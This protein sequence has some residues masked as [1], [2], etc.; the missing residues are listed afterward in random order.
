MLPDLAFLESKFAN[1]A[2]AI[3]GVHS[4]KFDNERNT[5]P[6]RSAVLR[7]DISHPVVND[8]TMALWRAL[9]VS[10]WP[11]LAVVSPAGRLLLSLSGE[12]HRA[13]L[14]DVL[15]A[16]IEYYGERG[17][18]DATPLPLTL[19]KTKNPLLAASPLRFPGKIALDS[20]QGRLF[21][22]DSGNHRILVTTLQGKFLTAF[23]GNGAGL[24]D[25][26]AATAVFNRP[27]GVTYSSVR[28]C[29]YVCDTEN[30]AVREIDLTSGQVRTLVG[31]G[32]RAQDDYRG[33]AAGTAQ[34]LNSPWDCCLISSLTTSTSLEKESQENSNS[35]SGALATNKTTEEEEM[36][37]VAMAGQH[38]LWSVGLDSG[39]A[40]A[41][42]GTGAE[43]NQNGATGGSTAWAQ[44]SGVTFIPHPINQVLVADS[45]SSSIRRLNLLTGGGAACI[46]GD[47]LF[48]DNLF[49]F[50]DLDGAGTSALL[51]HPLGVAAVG[52]TAWVVDSY[53][54]KLKKINLADDTI[55]AVAG[56]GIPGFA[57]GPG[58]STAQLSEPGGVAVVS[59]DGSQVFIADTNNSLIRV[60]DPETES[61]STL[62]L[63]DVP[64]I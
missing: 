53:N 55:C 22:S 9:G 49:K 2:V 43:R 21:I 61:L 20:R 25:G 46:G 1:E 39:V 40:A 58:L 47:P 23:G 37:L 38:Q 63:K 35:T 52:D 15:T 41:V 64:R 34:R 51:Q 14:D 32:V 13:D 56:S 5:E 31:D 27:Q 16:A 48:S 24:L 62:H 4:A 59:E 10:S 45:E 30:H 57:D 28:N 11:T 7:Y 6:I 50:G 60:F 19:E 36:L 44:P 18:L 3:I 54:H 12:D 8:R 17:L 33:G 29:V 26:D 42:S